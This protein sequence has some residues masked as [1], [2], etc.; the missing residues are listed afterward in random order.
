MD[1]R[2]VASDGFCFKCGGKGFT[3]KVC[4]SCG[5]EPIKLYIDLNESNTD[6]FVEK[7]DE[8]GVPGK[9]RGVFWNAEILKKSFRSLENDRMF[10]RYVDQLDKINRVFAEGVLSSKSAIIIAPAGYS[11]M[12]FAYSCM[13]RALDAGLSVAPFLDTCELKRLLV[14][15]SEN[16]NYKLFGKVSYDDYVMADVCFV[17]VSKLP[18]HEWAYN[19]IQELLDRRTRKGLSTFVISRFSLEEISKR[20]RSNQ[21]GV[22]QTAVSQDDYKYP[23]VVAYRPL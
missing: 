21:F 15:S 16:P 7:I 20:D 4:S 22:L 9:Y 8:F 17:T 11:K 3:D 12:T 23:A 18:V 2:M 1:K 13:Q 14:L 10:Q 19:V 5:K 6:A